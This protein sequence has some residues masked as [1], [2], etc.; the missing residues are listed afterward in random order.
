MLPKFVFDPHTPREIAY[1]TE[2]RCNYPGCNCKAINSHI[3]QRSRYV[4]SIAEE[5]LVLQITDE[6]LQLLMD[7]D[8]NGNLFKLLSTK[9]AMS[10]PIFCDDRR[11]DQK[12]FKNI[13][14]KEI[15]LDSYDTYLRLS[16]RAYCAARSQEQRRA[17][18][19]DINPS[20]NTFCRGPLFDM[21][22]NYSHRV[23]DMMALG[24]ERCYVCMKQKQYDDYSFLRYTIPER[25]P[26]CLSD[27]IFVEDELMDAV[28][29]SKPFCPLFVHILPYMDRTEVIIGYEVNHKTAFIESFIKEWENT[30]D[31]FKSMMHLLSCAN[32]W[33]VSPS[34]FGKTTEERNAVCEHI[35]SKKIEFQMEGKVM[36]NSNKEEL[37]DY[38]RRQ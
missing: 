27:C 17:I 30:D 3:M 35:F 23:I 9:Q 36:D 31:Y 15:D 1:A 5:G 25:M 38:R 6:H 10:L 34:F 32:N 14:Q 21:Q 16:Y 37:N 4:K 12:L 22:K 26:V 24:I 33:C 7:G 2:V 19:Y 11:H 20:I 13:E 28:E 8:E 18:Q 29:N